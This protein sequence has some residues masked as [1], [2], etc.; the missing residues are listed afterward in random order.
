MFALALLPLSACAVARTDGTTRSKPRIEMYAGSY[1]DETG[2]SGRFRLLL[3]AA[4]PDRLH[5]EILPV[6]GGPVVIVDAGAGVASVSLVAERI[7]YLGSTSE[8]LSGAVGIPL[9]VEALVDLLLEGRSERLDDE[10]WIERRPAERRGTPDLLRVGWRGRTIS[11][12][13]RGRQRL[14]SDSSSLATGTV[15]EGFERKRLSDLPAE[16]RMDLLLGVGDSP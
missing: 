11:I 6:L 13:L 15:P 16:S 5:A 7:A 4:L 12:T 2:R 9:S 10:V 3:H 8:D 1:T 14:R